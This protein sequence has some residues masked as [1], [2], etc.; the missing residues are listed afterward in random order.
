MILKSAVSLG[1]VANQPEWPQRRQRWSKQLRGQN[2]EEQNKLSKREAVC[3]S[4]NKPQQ[5]KT[6]NRARRSL[7]SPPYNKAKTKALIVKKSYIH[8][9]QTISFGSRKKRRQM[10]YK[11]FSHG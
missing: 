8:N 7:L 5:N 11:F 2:G 3:S 9:S 4:M 1:D 10:V 6:L